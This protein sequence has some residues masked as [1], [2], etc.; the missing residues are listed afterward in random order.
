MSTAHRV[1][2]SR[3]DLKP[4]P[5][6]RRFL[7]LGQVR[8][9]I[10]RGQIATLSLRLPTPCNLRCVYC[11][12]SPASFLETRN[13]GR[14]LSFSELSDVLHQAARL[15]MRTL[16]VVGDG[17]PLL[18]RD[19][20]GDFLALVDTAN[21]LGASVIVFSNA[22]TLTRE[23]ALALNRRDVAFVAKQNSLD[24]EI[25]D[26]LA[27]RSGSSKRLARGIQSLIDAGFNACHPSRLAIHTVIC[28][29]NYQEL[30][31]MW[32]AWRRRNIVPYV[33]VW[34]PPRDAAARQRFL[35]EF[36]V[37]PAAVR[38]LFH[39]LERI[40]EEEFGY[41]WDPDATYPIAAL[42]C[43]A[44]LTGCGI[45]PTGDVQIC[46]YTEEVLGS[47]RERS[48]QDIMNSAAAQQI[49]SHFSG[50]TFDGFQR[51]CHALTVNLKGDRYAEDPFFWE[52]P[53]RQAK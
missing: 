40:D 9:V 41:A 5:S 18:Y 26:Y 37:E 27:G 7:S 39:R 35:S 17:E 24:P 36:F 10:R 12:S 31:Q 21:R 20:D 3:L 38:D 6:L 43:T 44:A 15:G 50:G 14:A 23:Q 30:P 48:L 2:F 22:L 25:Q 19:P 4:P 33:Q 52:A 53:C 42:G 34:V 1:L 16:S 8:E 28:R 46:A 51:R 32:R 49:R 13:G 29:Q 45:T 11:Y 47:V